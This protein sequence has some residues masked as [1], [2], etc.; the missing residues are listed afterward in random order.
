M[1]DKQRTGPYNEVVV[2]EPTVRTVPDKVS[3]V[4]IHRELSTV[5]SKGVPG[6]NATN[7]PLS[8]PV[9]DIGLT[10]SPVRG[11]TPGGR[12][13]TRDV[14]FNDRVDVTD[15]IEVHSPFS[16]PSGS[17]ASAATT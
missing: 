15:I 5:N 17:G 14:E 16:V 10:D 1:F 3:D 13:V 4:A 9:R 11:P 12:R 6:T 7:E 2:D 8:Y